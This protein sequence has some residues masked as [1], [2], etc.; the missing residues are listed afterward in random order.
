MN[1][2]GKVGILIDEYDSPINSV[3]S[4]DEISKNTEIFAYFLRVIK[5]LDANLVF[6]FLTGI[7]PQI[8]ST[9]QSGT[10][11]FLDFTFDGRFEDLC[12][13]NHEDMKK[14]LQHFGIKVTEDIIKVI[15]GYSFSFEK[16]SEKKRNTVYNNFFLSRY[17]VT[18]V[19]DDYWLKTFS[20]NIFNHIKGV[21]FQKNVNLNKNFTENFVVE[22]T[23]R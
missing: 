22:S 7:E 13:S 14:I 4:E 19:L 20:L 3:K 6:C 16:D 5:V 11:N 2:W 1:K 8:I 15:K 18:K 21:S 9:M 17:A 23:E 10:N 12:G